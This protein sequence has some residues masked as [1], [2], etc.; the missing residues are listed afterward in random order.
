M[1]GCRL[2]SQPD[3]DLDVEA[4][5]EWYESE[6]SGLGFEF[7]DE[8]RAVLRRQLNASALGGSDMRR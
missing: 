5:F 7:L 8:L 3:A 6:R 2:V 1:T 4:A